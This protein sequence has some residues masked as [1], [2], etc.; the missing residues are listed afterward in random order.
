MVYRYLT[1][2][3]V[4]EATDIYWTM[5]NYWKPAWEG[6]IGQIWSSEWVICARKIA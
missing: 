3:E 6:I 4:I 2:G 1:E 5:T